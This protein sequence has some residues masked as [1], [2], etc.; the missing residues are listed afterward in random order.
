MTELFSISVIRYCRCDGCLNTGVCISQ[1]KRVSSS[2]KKSSSSRTQETSKIYLP[3]I[4]AVQHWTLSKGS[5]PLCA[6][7]MQTVNDRRMFARISGEA[8]NC[9]CTWG[10]R[11]L[12]F[13]PTTKIRAS[14]RLCREQL[15]PST[16]ELQSELTGFLSWN[17]SHNF[18]ESI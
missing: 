14:N 7:V 9:A 3:E 5:L 11:I 17:W 10:A 16:F 1:K 15:P 8:R 6:I 18:D 12:F 2:E 4:R 13:L